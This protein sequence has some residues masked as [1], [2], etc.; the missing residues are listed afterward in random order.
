MASAVA[1][2]GARGPVLPRDYRRRSLPPPDLER[3]SPLP[4]EWSDPEKVVGRIADML[5]KLLSDH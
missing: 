1:V 5:D 3:Q 4:E 2:D